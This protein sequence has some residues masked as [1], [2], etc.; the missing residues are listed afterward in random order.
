[1]SELLGQQENVQRPHQQVR[2]KVDHTIA[3]YAICRQSL[4]SIGHKPETYTFVN[5]A[6]TEI[7]RFN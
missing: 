7:Q 4:N 5:S 3:I 1:M 6:P 2:L